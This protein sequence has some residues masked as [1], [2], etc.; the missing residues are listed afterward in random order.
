LCHACRSF[1]TLDDISPLRQIAGMK[2]S[3]GAFLFKP[4]SA[5]RSGAAVFRHA[6]AHR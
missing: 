5:Y 2:A 1:W 6:S 4:G 3:A